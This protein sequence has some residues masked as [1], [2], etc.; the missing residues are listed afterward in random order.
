MGVG[1]EEG[2]RNEW[3][4]AFWRGREGGLCRSIVEMTGCCC[5]G[6]GSVLVCESRAGGGGWR[7]YV[8]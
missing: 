5:G 7:C 1:K 4:K 3:R 8:N 2:A 6:R